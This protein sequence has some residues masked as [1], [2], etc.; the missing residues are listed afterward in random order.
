MPKREGEYFLCSIC[1]TAYKNIRDAF[2]CEKNH[3]LITIALTPEELQGLLNFIA[4][5]DWNALPATVYNKLRNA[6][7]NWQKPKNV[8]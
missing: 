8:V 2:K 6:A 4:V 1:N 3:E 5:G 7:I